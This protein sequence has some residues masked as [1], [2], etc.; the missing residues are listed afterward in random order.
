MGPT[1]YGNLRLAQACVFYGSPAGSFASGSRE[2]IRTATSLAHTSARL[3]ITY[4][5][6]KIGRTRGTY[7][8]LIN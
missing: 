6:L 5:T 1:N 2:L 7:A 8:T 3:I 4:A